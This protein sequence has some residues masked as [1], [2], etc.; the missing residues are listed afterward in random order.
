[1][2]ALPRF[3][4]PTAGRGESPEVRALDE[5]G[6]QG[7]GGCQHDPALRRKRRCTAQEVKE[8][9]TRAGGE[10]G[11]ALDGPRAAIGA[12][13]TVR[14]RCAGQIWA[15]LARKAPTPDL[16]YRAAP[17][18]RGQVAWRAAVGAASAGCSASRYI[19]EGTSAAS[20]RR[21]LPDRTVRRT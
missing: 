20:T 15:M 11:A 19:R 8:G 16:P 17:R 10:P 12:H 6:E 1:M 21:C 5:L 4:A 14:V 18:Y 3:E 7:W 9:I 13:R 2:L